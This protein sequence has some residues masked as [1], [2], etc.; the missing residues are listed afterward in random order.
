MAENKDAYCDICGK[1]LTKPILVQVIDQIQAW[2]F[3]CSKDVDK[4]N[5]FNPD[6]EEW[7]IKY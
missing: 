4:H 3:D 6:Q 5:I 2:C 1:L 7:E